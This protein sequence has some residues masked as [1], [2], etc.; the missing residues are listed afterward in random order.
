MANQWKHIGTAPKDGRDILVCLPGGMSD[1][2]FPVCWND[3]DGVWECRWHQTMRLTEEEI[4]RC[5][6][7]PMWMEIPTPPSS[8]CASAIVSDSPGRYDLVEKAQ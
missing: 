4:A 6:L 3:E 7:Q 2:F 5:Y 8:L 1:H